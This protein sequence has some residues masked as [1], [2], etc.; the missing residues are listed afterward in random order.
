MCIE[1]PDLHDR[2]PKMENTPN[3]PAEY[4]SQT[5]RAL[6]DRFGEHRGAIQNKDTDAYRSTLTRRDTNSRTSNF[7]HSNLLILKGN[8]YVELVK[9]FI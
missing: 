6:R 1:K 8:P 5:K 7:F 9:H 4:I 3:A 2:M